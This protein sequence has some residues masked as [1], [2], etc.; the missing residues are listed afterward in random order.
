MAAMVQQEIRRVV[1]QEIWKMVEQEIQ[2][3]RVQQEPEQQ[4][5]AQKD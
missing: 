1:Q 3:A 2:V 4:K 5:V